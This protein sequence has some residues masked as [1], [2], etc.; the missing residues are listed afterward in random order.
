MRRV[1]AEPRPRQRP[2]WLR[3]TLGLV[4]AAVLVVAALAG[5]SRIGGAASSSSSSAADR[6]AAP[7]SSGGEK[8]MP[9]ASGTARAFV[10]HVPAAQLPRLLGVGA[11]DHQL[12]QAS[13]IACQP[14]RIDVRV[15]SAVYDSL[16]TQL[17]QAAASGSAARRVT[18]VLHRGGTAVRTLRVTCP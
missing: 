5:I 17:R 15:P 10:K 11:A 6:E 2:T 8:L 9:Q 7:A 3:P 12:A 16:Q 14:A 18:V 13:V 4:A 1:R